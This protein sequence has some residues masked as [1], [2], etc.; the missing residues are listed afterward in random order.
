MSVWDVFTGL[1]VWVVVGALLGMAVGKVLRG[2]TR[3]RRA[4]FVR[5]IP[6]PRTMS[7][8]TAK[9]SELA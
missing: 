3:A 8:A 5:S 1:A 2:R 6:R 9:R 7:T 4:L